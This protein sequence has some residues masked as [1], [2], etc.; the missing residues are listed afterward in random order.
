MLRVPSNA[1][2]QTLATASP[3]VAAA[4]RPT[5][6]MAAPHLH[7]PPLAVTAGIQTLA[8]AA[9]QQAEKGNAAAEHEDGAD[10]LRKEKDHPLRQ[11]DRRRR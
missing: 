1:Q 11:G 4:L 2:V 10:P 7:P 5:V 9:L 6:P 3:Q 8:A